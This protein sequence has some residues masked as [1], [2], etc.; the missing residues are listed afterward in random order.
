MS[1]LSPI[2]LCLLIAL[3]APALHSV[4][5]RLARYTLPLAPAGVAA[6]F[7]AFVPLVLRGEAPSTSRPWVT[8]L[9]LSLAFRVDGLSLLLAL[10]ITAV[11]A[12]VILYAGAYLRAHQHLGR[13]YGFLFLFMASML[14]VVLAD[15]T[16]ALFIFWE[17]TSLSSYFLIGFDH[18][19]GAARAAALQAL[20]VTGAGGLALLAAVILLGQVTGT[21]ELSA[22]SAAARAELHEHALYTP[23]VVLFLFAAFTKSAQFP[24]HFWLPRAMEAPTPVSAYLHAAT[25]VK[26]GVYLLARLTP[27][28]SGPNAWHWSLIGIGATTA[29]A[30]AAFAL[31][32]QHFKRVLAYS[33]VAALGIM[34]F[35][36]GIGTTGALQAAVLFLL[37]HALYKGALFLV[38]GAVDHATHESNVERL[39][40][41][42]SALPATAAVATV[43][44]L[45]MAGVPPL[46]GYV[47]KEVT[48]AATVDTWAPVAITALA[49]LVNALFF[50]IAINVGVRPFHG[51]VGVVRATKEVDWPLWFAPGLLAGLGLLLGI[52]PAAVDGVVRAA[53]A[54]ARPEAMAPHLALWHGFR[55]LALSGATLLIGFGFFK[56]R[57]VLRALARRLAPLARIGPARG[58]EAGLRVLTEMARLQT[59]V[60]QCG[61]LSVYLL[62]ILV[63]AGALV[64]YAL[65]AGGTRPLVRREAAD[66]R[67]FEVVVAALV[68]VATV[69][70]IRARSRFPA[71][72]SLGVVGYGVAVVFILF[73]APDLGITQLAVE[74]LTVILLVLAFYHLPKFTALSAARTRLRDGVVSILFGALM[75]ALVLVASGTEPA[76][77]VATY[78]GEASVPE[79]H[80][81][82]VVNVILTDFRAL[83]TLGEVTVVAVAALG[84]FA[85][86]KLRAR[87]GGGP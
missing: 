17:L 71:I 37:A 75:T 20:L 29:F 19:R 28:L 80:G 5:P 59:R 16:I 15:N 52:W 18:Q 34:V 26:A 12:L 6:Y 78:Y 79:A 24:F 77:K 8:S 3:G 1:I 49:F 36:I 14:G 9:G 82:N 54:S 22:I 65:F 27:I 44:A 30:G 62:V 60:L 70:A 47:S 31:G 13:L 66:L 45:S 87:E 23:M 46:L 41:L 84:V 21:Y 7:F 58:Y 4:A 55:A 69:S 25:M 33:T 11:G 86:L 72:L 83:D 50:A 2:L 67:F 51:R 73:G 48:Y 10:L 56:A 68:L 43:A 74:T 40:G 35:L 57:F 38:A 81:R 85:L 32:E 64:G 53:T 63:T 76:R 61:S 39:G 42:R